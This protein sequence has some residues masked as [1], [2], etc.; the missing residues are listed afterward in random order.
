MCVCALR[1]SSEDTE[2]LQAHINKRACEAELTTATLKSDTDGGKR[3]AQRDREEEE[4][5]EEE[6]D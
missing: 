3:D 2:S 4:S 5:A 6:R 1:V